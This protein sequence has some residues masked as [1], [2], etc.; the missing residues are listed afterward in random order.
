MPLP[1]MTLLQELAIT[2]VAMLVGLFWASV[3]V[4]LCAW[5]RAKNHTRRPK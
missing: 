4:D 5:I 1:D 2:S 3:L